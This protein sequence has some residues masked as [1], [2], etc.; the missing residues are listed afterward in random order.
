MV[1]VRVLEQ[2][3]ARLRSERDKYRD[4]WLKQ[5]DINDKLRG[6]LALDSQRMADLEAMVR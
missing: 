3:N 5:V 6:M 4:R 1:A 2:E